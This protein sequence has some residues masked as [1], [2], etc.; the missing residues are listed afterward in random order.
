MNILR[1][2]LDELPRCLPEEIDLFICSASFEERCRL[3]A[4][5][6]DPWRVRCAL[7]AENENHRELHGDN[8]RYLMD[9][10]GSSAVPVMLDT[11][12]PLK[13]ADSLSAALEKCALSE[14]RNLCVDVTTFTHEGFLIL[15]SLL[16]RNFNPDIVKYLYSSAREYSI[17]DPVDKKWLSKGIGEVRS[18]LGYPGEMLPSRK[19]HLIVLVGFEHERVRELITRYEPSVISLG[20]GDSDEPGAETHHAANKHGFEMVKA[21]FGEANEFTFSCYEPL[22]TK[23]AIERQMRLSPECNVVVA[24]M[25]TKPSTIGAA[26][27]ALENEA[28]QLCYAQALLYNYQHYST[29][30]S[31]CYI[32]DSI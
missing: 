31:H 1:I 30:G 6:I 17:G 32:F 28:I 22:E 24:A 14:P 25:N 9:R 12:K 26:L 20:Y 10:F 7:V 11:G 3:V 15:F 5:H 8:A 27:A 2:P 19:L 16:K 21:L 4:N 29:P 13:T 23:S 18:V